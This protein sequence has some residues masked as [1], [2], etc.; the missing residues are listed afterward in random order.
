[1]HDYPKQL[2]LGPQ[3]VKGGLR[4]YLI[5]ATALAHVGEPCAYQAEFVS[6]GAAATYA[7][8]ETFRY[9]PRAEIGISK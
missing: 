7:H 1:M 8:S 4:I 6:G 2:S 3:R 5:D 9:R